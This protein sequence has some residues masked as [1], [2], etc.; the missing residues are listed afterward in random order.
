[1]EDPFGH[2]LIKGL[3][4]GSELG[5]GAGG[6]FLSDGFAQLSDDAAHV[7]THDLVPR[8]PRETL[9]VTLDC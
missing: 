3:H 7:R 9:A 1:M 4:D 2:R 8:R 6:I 5:G